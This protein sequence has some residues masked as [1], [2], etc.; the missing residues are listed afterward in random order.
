MNIGF[1]LFFIIKREPKTFHPSGKMPSFLNLASFLSSLLFFLQLGRLYSTNRVRH[2]CF[3]NLT[4]GFSLLLFT[5][6]FH[7]EFHFCCGLVM[8][9]ALLKCIFPYFDRFAKHALLG[10]TF[11]LTVLFSFYYFFGFIA[12]CLK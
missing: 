10:L 6:G 8:Q 2:V 1:A 3:H 5:E 4:V 7:V 12:C 9:F 11:N